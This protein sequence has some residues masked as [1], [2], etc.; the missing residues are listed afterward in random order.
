MTKPRAGKLRRV[1]CSLGAKVLEVF[2]I[3]LNEEPCLLQR[4][5]EFSLEGLHKLRCS[6]MR[7]ASVNVSEQDILHE[8]LGWRKRPTIVFDRVERGQDRVK[9]VISE[10]GNAL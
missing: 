3:L 6:L 1:L 2:G 4:A 7:E 9:V 8:G 5:L 10:A